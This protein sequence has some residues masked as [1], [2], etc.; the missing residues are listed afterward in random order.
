MA[1]PSRKRRKRDRDRQRD[2][3]E[4][5]VG[6]G[7]G[8]GVGEKEKLRAGDITGTPR[9]H[10]SPPLWLLALHPRTLCC[11]FFFLIEVQLIC[12][13]VLVSGVHV[14]MLSRFSCV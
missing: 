11:F 9:L 3:V 8:R 12:D 10:S 13:I 14:C 7:E 1:T 2:E 5:E 6:R 4:G